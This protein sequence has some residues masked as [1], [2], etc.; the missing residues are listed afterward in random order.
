MAAILKISRFIID[1]LHVVYGELAN[2]FTVKHIYFDTI[3]TDRLEQVHD[4]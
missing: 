4:F 1:S 3:P 2:V